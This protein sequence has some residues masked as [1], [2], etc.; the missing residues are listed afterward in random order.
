M[1]C[2]TATAIGARGV[3]CLA[4]PLQPPRRRTATADPP[5]RLDEL[6][7]VPV[8]VLVVQGER[9]RFG[10]PPDGPGRT[11]VAVPGDHRLAADVGAVA[12]A[13]QRWLAGLLAG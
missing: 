1:A 12:A 6:D 9:D 2:R 5:S 3:L 8:P 10:M 4:F 7:A 13:A 11:V